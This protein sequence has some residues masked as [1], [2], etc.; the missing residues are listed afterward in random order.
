[1]IR[2]PRWLWRFVWFHVYYVWQIVVANVVVGRDIVTPGSRMSAGFIEV[3]LRCRTRFEIMMMANFIT[4]TPGTVTVAVH[5]DARTLW[6]HSLYITSPD[7]LRADIRAMEEHLLRAT[8]LD[9]PPSE[10]P[11]VGSW[12]EAGRR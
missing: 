5:E 11:R 7:E 2:Y 4:L 1:M 6:V 10:V 3:P 8:R 9:G 12:R